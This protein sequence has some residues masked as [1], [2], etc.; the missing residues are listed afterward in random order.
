ML[1]RPQALPAGGFYI[2]KRGRCISTARRS[3]YIRNNML[4]AL[5]SI[6]NRLSPYIL[7]RISIDTCI[8]KQLSTRAKCLRIVK[9]VAQIRTAF[10]CV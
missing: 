6:Y 8:F 3:S 4:P 1:T 9:I 10:L 5:A 2:P 7:K